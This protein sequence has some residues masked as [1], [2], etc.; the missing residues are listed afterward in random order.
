MFPRDLDVDTSK[1]DLFR[2]NEETNIHCTK[3]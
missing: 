1:W 2:R 3:I